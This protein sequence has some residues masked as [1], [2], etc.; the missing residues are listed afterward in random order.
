ME[1]FFRPFIAI[2][3][4]VRA[5]FTFNFSSLKENSI[6]KQEKD[7]TEKEMAELLAAQKEAGL[8]GLPCTSI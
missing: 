7:E 2:Y 6:P 1:Q 4:V 8:S 3:H 5:L